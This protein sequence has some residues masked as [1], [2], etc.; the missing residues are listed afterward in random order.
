MSKRQLIVIGN[1]FDLACNLKSHFYD[2]FRGRFEDI[3]DI[4]DYHSDAWKAAV[5]CSSL[6][7]WDFILHEAKGSDWCDIESAIRDWVVL[8]D[9]WPGDWWPLHAVESRMKKCPFSGM[10]QVTAEN[11]LESEEDS[12]DYVLGNVSR[13][14]WMR[15]GRE[16]AVNAKKADIVALLREELAAIERLFDQY[17]GKQVEGNGQYHAA[18]QLLLREMAVDGRAGVGDSLANTS[19]L[20]F[21]Y[22]NPFEGMG[23]AGFVLDVTNVHGRL[24]S[25]IIFGID[26]TGRMDD[27]LALPFTK[28]YRVVS[29]GGDVSRE[30]LGRDIDTIKFF[31]HSLGEA[32]YSYFQ[33]LFD[34]V[35][36][37]GGS[38]RLV[39]YYRPWETE[40]GPISEEEV[41]ASMV[42]RVAKLLNTYGKTMDN[43]D[44]GKNLM[45]KLLL[46]GRLEVK[47]I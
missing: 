47:L 12:R 40:E 32:D 5:E 10:V 1:G 26:S 30:M 36:L 42:R 9:R 44:H 20:S 39:F 41:R 31:G 16:F 22:T 17:L 2:F 6:T 18:A 45:H 21:N 8:P 38:T 4:H 23:L 14:V 11:R 46:E 27:Q 19:I 34:S 13:Y 43:A 35:G 15:K 7:A 33:S 29:M 28:T 25:E 37:Y 24:G 3:D